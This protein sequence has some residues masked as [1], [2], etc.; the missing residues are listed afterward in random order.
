MDGSNLSPG[1]AWRDGKEK[2]TVGV[3]AEG[4]NREGKNAALRGF[5]IAIETSV[6]TVPGN[7]R[8]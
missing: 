5:T 1:V 4:I 8:K 3:T 7:S 6:E 2:A